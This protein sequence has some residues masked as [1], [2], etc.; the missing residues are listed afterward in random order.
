MEVDFKGRVQRGA[1]GAGDTGSGCPHDAA[2]TTMRAHC[3]NTRSMESRVPISVEMLE[4]EAAKAAAGYAKK[5]NRYVRSGEFISHFQDHAEYE[6][7]QLGLPP[8][9]IGVGNRQS[10]PF[11]LKKNQYVLGAYF[12]KEM[13]VWV[14]ADSSGPLLGISFKSMMR[15]VGQNVNN[16]WEELV[17]DAANIHSRFPMLS[18][19]YVMILPAMSF[20]GS[21]ADEMP[22]PLIDPSTGGPTN[23]ALQ[24]ERKLLGIRGRKQPVELPSV[25]EEVALAVFDFGLKRPKLHPDFPRPESP[26][27][28]ERFYEELVGHFQRRNTYVPQQPRSQ[29]ESGPAQD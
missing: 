14:G 2:R 6:L 10:I 18:L 19:G 27:R 8:A 23:L 15:G 5:P 9:D 20:K 26:L 11:H 22:E 21:G 13:D 7:M 12:P 25:Y 1:I 24:I 3:R 4:M 16:R 28:I 17:G 29:R